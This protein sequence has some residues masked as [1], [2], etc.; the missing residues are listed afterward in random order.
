MRVF[1][2]MVLTMGVVALLTAPAMAQQGKGQG[3]GGFGGGMGGG[4]AFL[5]A[6]NVQKDLKLTDNQI[7][8]VQETLRDIREKHADDYAALRDASPEERQAKMRTLN[9]TVSEE[10]KKALALTS[11]QSTRYDQISLQTRGFQAFADP[12]VASRLKLTDDQK[13]QI[14]EIAESSRGAFAGGFNKDASEEERAAAR[15]KMASTQRS[16]MAKVQAL[17]TDDQKKS[18]KEMT[19]DPIQPEYPRRPNN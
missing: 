19:G 18:W 2:K 7:G 12:T 1:G 4:A 8:K 5:M 11:E 15:E 14:R 3:R 10:V 13:S 9:E 17:L 16:N 6:P